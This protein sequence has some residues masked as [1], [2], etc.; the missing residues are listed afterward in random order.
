L[1]GEV[2]ATHIS[3]FEYYELFFQRSKGNVFVK[4][5]TF[6]YTTQGNPVL[7]FLCFYIVLKD[8]KL[9]VWKAGN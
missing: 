5:R 1:G 2:E 6:C 4:Q 8:M 3:N 7:I 9:A